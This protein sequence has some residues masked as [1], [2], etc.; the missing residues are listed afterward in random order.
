MKAASIFAGIGGFDAGLAEAKHQ[1]ILN[2][3]IHPAAN[4]VLREHFSHVEHH[5]DVTTLAD[6]P[7][8]VELLCAGFPCQDLSQAGMTAGIGGQRSSLVGEVFR[9]LQRRR[10]PRVIIENVPF[11]LHLQGGR[12]LEFIVGHLEELGYR[13]AYRVVN[14]L[15]FGLPQRRE[16]VFLVAAIDVDPAD[17][18]LVDDVGVRES[19]AS[20]GEFAHGFYWT[21]GTR[22]LGWAPDAVP[23]LKNGSTVGI[24]SPPAILMPDGV[25]IKPSIQDA[26]RLQ[27]FPEDWTKPAEGVAKASWRWSLV[28]NAV[29]APVAAWIGRRLSAPGQYSRDRDR[30]LPGNRGWP[31]AARYDG[32]SRH[33]VAISTA[34]VWAARPPLHRFLHH[35]GTLLSA[36][37]TGGFLRRARASSLHFVD[38]FLE[39]VAVHLNRM[40]I[41]ERE[42]T[43]TR[44]RRR[45]DAG[46]PAFA[47]E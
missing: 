20:L 34:P 22:G 44:R 27:G 36:K 40:T 10:V 47:A 45:G 4:A 16:R 35:P 8:D 17:V 25:V 32:T 13:W 9:L 6:L 33:E 37:A 26:E 15:A 12:A 30:S 21:E 19:R 46:A 24:P 5:D 18:L 7:S 38:G 42:T 11:M 23:T 2:C 41:L 31:K 43:A 28:G 3:E 14:T 1:T 39:A 29:S